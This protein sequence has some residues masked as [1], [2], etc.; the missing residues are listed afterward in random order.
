[1]NYQQCKFLI[2]EAVKGGPA[3]DFEV[4]FI[5]EVMPLLGFNVNS[6]RQRHPSGRFTIWSWEKER[7]GAE[8]FNVILFQYHTVEDVDADSDIAFDVRPVQE[9]NKSPNFQ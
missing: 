7:D 9:Q 4:R 2:L 1:M 6:F 8:D 5:E 3:T